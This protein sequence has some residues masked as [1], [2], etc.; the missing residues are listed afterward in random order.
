MV[1]SLGI[2]PKLQD[3]QSCVL[4][5]ELRGRLVIVENKKNTVN[6]FLLNILI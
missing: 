4:S 1:S 3:P 5:V 2:E 6:I